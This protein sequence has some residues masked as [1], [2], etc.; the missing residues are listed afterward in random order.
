MSRNKVLFLLNALSIALF[1]MGTAVFGESANVPKYVTVPVY[2]LTDRNL[3][4]D[5]YGNHRRY[6]TNCLH[7]MYYGTAFITVENRNHERHDSHFDALGWKEANQKETHVSPK[8]RIDPSHPARAKVEFFERLR[9]ALDQLGSDTICV[10]VH[11]AAEGFEDACLDA[12][13]F[14]YHL[15]RPLVLYSWPAEPK[16]LDYLVDNNNSEW[17]QGHFMLFDRDL[18]AFKA[19]HPLRV[20][21]LAH[22]MGNRFIFRAIHQLYRN[23]LV[24][25]LELISP[26]IDLDT[27]RHYLMGFRRVDNRTAIRL[28]VSN[29]DRMLKIS[30]SLFGGYTRL[31]EHTEQNLGPTRLVEELTVRKVKDK[32]DSQTSSGLLQDTAFQ[33]KNESHREEE[34]VDQELYGGSE[35]TGADV[36]ERI[37][38]TAIDKGLTGHSIPFQLVTDMVNGAQP[39][40]LE[41]VEDQNDRQRSRAKV[42]QERHR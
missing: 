15:K 12:A 28:Y 41:L 25:D 36:F 38:F 16:L 18:V 14:A 37:D 40:G 5:T 7:R 19:N 31:G 39:A 3:E 33:D 34:S 29:R 42:V 1:C 13:E 23:E 17:S 30:Q 32:H 8:N 26:D 22:S 21:Y 11:G 24:A 35:R 9:N 10:Y 2:Y 27:C 6:Q 4:G 20:V